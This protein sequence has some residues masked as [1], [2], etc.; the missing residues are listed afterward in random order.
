MQSYGYSK[1]WLMSYI[2]PIK[3]I[4]IVQFKICMCNFMYEV[5]AAKYFIPWGNVANCV[6][7][8][9]Q[10]LTTYN[11]LSTFSL[12]V[13]M[14]GEKVLRV[15]VMSEGLTKAVVAADRVRSRGARKEGS[16]GVDTAPLVPAGEPRPALWPVLGVGLIAPFCSAICRLRSRDVLLLRTVQA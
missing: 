13:G 12:L 5:N 14:F 16:R 15:L 2:K 1:Y 6:T 7:V 10:R 3:E 9:L 11:E 4:V 8:A